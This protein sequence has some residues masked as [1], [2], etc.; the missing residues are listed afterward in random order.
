MPDDALWGIVRDALSRIE[1]KVDDV[2]RD[3]GEKASARDL[4]KLD[5]RVVTLEGDE[6]V[7]TA[8]RRNWEDKRIRARDL[9]LAAC[10]IATTAALILTAVH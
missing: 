5:E 7:V 10:T 2:S 8:V 9:V 4:E 6:R 1:R 3:L